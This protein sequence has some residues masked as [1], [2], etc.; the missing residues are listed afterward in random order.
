MTN[1]KQ[2]NPLLETIEEEEDRDTPR[3]PRTI[4]K[5]DQILLSAEYIEEPEADLE[6]SGV[7][8]P[9]AEEH[10]AAEEIYFLGMNSSTGRDYDF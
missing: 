7:Y 2:T 6:D 4:R 3:C 8:I 9:P 5:R 10:F 1:R